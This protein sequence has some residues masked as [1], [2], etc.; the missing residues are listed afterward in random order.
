MLP[1]DELGGAEQILRMIASYHLSI[2]DEVY[3]YFG[4]KRIDD[5]WSNLDTNKNAHLFYGKGGNISGLCYSFIFMLKVRS[6]F[7][8]RV[9][10]S[11]VY[12]NGI[13][14]FY[15]K[16]GI[17]RAKYLIGRESTS[18]FER[19][20]GAKLLMYK[21]F[22]R[23]G[24]KN[25]DLLICQTEFMKQQLQNG[26]A[27]IARNINLQVLHNPIDLRSIITQPEAQSEQFINR[28][29]YIVSAGRLI[30][31]KGFD[32]L[33][34]AFHKISNKYKDV[35]LIILGEGKERDA[36]QKNVYDLELNARVI[37]PG[38]FDNVYPLFKHAKLC[39]VSS[40]IEGFPN[41]LLQMMSQNT[42]VISTLCVQEISN[43]KG[44]PTCYPNDVNGLA[45]LMDENLLDNEENLNE[46]V[47]EFAAYLGKNNIESY[48]MSISKYLDTND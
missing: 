37:L 14:G 17:L 43:I 2:G 38:R 13:L 47:K 41:T 34:N 46:R 5:G 15:K 22:Y 42:N 6:F 44:L 12:Y 30:K 45:T 19:Y 7:F 25:L 27:N 16:C 26:I 3:I 35:N 20:S 10:S 36:L 48:M 23:L 32:I 9:Y 29:K 8:E 4:V 18:I 11:N 24:Y 28:M 39:V 31:E 21:F 1:S 40:R 33:I